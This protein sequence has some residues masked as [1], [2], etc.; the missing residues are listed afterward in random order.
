[1]RSSPSVVFLHGWCGQPDELEA[2]RDLLPERLLAPAWMPA[3]GTL[4]PADWRAAPGPGMDAAML[5]F[6]DVLLA[7]LR[8][9]ILAAGFEGS[10]LIGHSMGGAMA[11]LLA[12]DPALAAAGLVLIDSSVPMPPQ[13]RAEGTARMAH[14]LERVQRE[15]LAAAQCAWVTSMPERTRPYFHPNDQGPLRQQVERRMAQAPVLE[16][17]AALGGAVQW[18]VDAALQ[19]VRCPIL[20]LAA[21]PARLPL[22]AFRAARPDAQLVHRAGCGHFLHLFDP[23]FLRQTLRPWLALRWPALQE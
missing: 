5:R 17:A 14:W 15:G 6:A 4:D 13:R 23:A 22:N 8:T 3:P 1:M 19:A 9:T 11:L 12:A 2:W 18:D 10:V 7:R 16:A 20:A 21:D